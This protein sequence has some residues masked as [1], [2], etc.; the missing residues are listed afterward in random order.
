MVVAVAQLALF[1]S[2]LGA[3]ISAPISLK[4]CGWICCPHI[5]PLFGLGKLKVA[6]RFWLS[7]VRHLAMGL[8]QPQCT[9]F[10]FIKGL[11]QVLSDSTCRKLPRSHCPQDNKDMKMILISHFV[12]C[13][14]PFFQC[15]LL[16]VAK[17]KIFCATWK[18]L[19]YYLFSIGGG[20]VA[21][22]CF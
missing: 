22:I 16:L 14:D 11:L 3:K 9:L 18:F 19:K 4:Y 8:Y 10:M 1:N 2:F 5:L 13:S 17:W 15:Y 12:S 20:I 7:E 21:E 6:S